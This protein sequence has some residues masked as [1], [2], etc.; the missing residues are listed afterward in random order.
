MKLSIENSGIVANLER[1]NR[2]YIEYIK[3]LS[4]SKHSIDLYSRVLNNFIEYMREYDEEV[5]MDKIT[6]IYFTGFL[7]FLED[8]AKK[9]GNKQ[10]H[11]YYLSKSSKQTY[12]K[13]IKNFFEFISDNNDD[14]FSYTRFLKGVK[15]NDSSSNEEKIKHFTEEEISLL[16]N[17][18]NKA[19]SLAK[20][21]RSLSLA[22]RNSLL[23]KMLLFG[24]L[25]ISEAL[26]LKV[27]DIV[28]PVEKG[29]MIA[30]KVYGKGGKYQ[31]SFIPSGAIDEELSFFLEELKL[32]TKEWL[33]QTISKNQLDRHSAYKGIQRVYKKA[34]VKQKG[35]HTLRHT[36]GMRLTKKNVNPLVIQRILRHSSLTTTTVYAK[37]QKDD[38][39]KGLESAMV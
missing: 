31:D 14:L 6:S 26:N 23:V 17:E 38:I 28:L 11:G 29:G 10:K 16:L 9:R 12:L 34:G 4:Y 18:L 3:S 25:R 24:G 13:A 19:I 22:Y 15:I 1:W 21:N 7:T 5:T 8:E 27:E 36:L 32:D 35:L 2:F 33:F 39:K 30:V 37:A 20:N